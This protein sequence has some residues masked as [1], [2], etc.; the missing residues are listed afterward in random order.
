MWTKPTDFNDLHVLQGLDAVKEQIERVA[1]PIRTSWRLSSPEQTAW[2]SPRSIG[3]WMITLRA[4]A[5]R[6]CLVTQAVASLRVHRHWPAVWP[7]ASH[8]MGMK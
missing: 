6:K 7:L 2:N 4:T 5:W 1:G 8:G 3:W